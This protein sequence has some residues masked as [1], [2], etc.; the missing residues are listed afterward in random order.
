MKISPNPSVDH[1]FSVMQR[2]IDGT[3][4][5]DSI[6]E[7]EEILE[8]Y[9]NDPLLYRRYADLL[10][11]KGR[12][13]EAN[14]A[15]QRTAELFIELN[16]S[17]QAIV[18]KILQWSIQKPSHEQGREF[19]AQLHEEGS[20]QTPLQKFWARMRYSELIAVM[21]RLVRLRLPAGTI[22]NKIGEPADDLF[23]IVSGSVSELI[24]SK[25]A[26][27][28][29]GSAAVEPE[30][31]LLAENDIFGDIFPLHHPTRV[32]KEVQ[33]VSDVEMVK[34]AKSVLLGV[35]QKHPQIESLLMKMYKPEN[36]RE[37]STERTWQTVRRNMRFG[38]PTSVDITFL[39]S[40]AGKDEW[41]H[42]AIAV[43]L[44]LGGVCL[45]LG[46]LS[47]ALDVTSLKG[48]L[49]RIRLSLAEDNQD[50]FADGTV[51]WLNR[52]DNIHNQDTLLGVRFDPLS[53]IDRD[54]LLDFCTDRGGEQNLL[55][56]L[57]DT[58]VNTDESG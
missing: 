8:I 39:P 17:L 26:D 9:E 15:Y 43:D 52:R 49:V 27:G 33:A 21:L 58:M 22:V 53:G 34:I 7:F 37:G 57:W 38:L 42:R 1:Q 32:Q 54:R 50:L 40:S 12:I 41:Q 45:D 44:S 23:F 31:V 18:A 24:S 51:V 11:D 13:L 2:I 55:W 30:P 25:K 29:E 56:S 4:T 14:Q 10:N 35:C 16:M 6:E 48:R 36:R 3:L 47:E 20:R 19:Y 46:P 5:I 28:S